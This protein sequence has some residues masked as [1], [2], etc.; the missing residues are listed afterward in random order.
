MSNEEKAIEWLPLSEA[1]KLPEVPVT[2]QSL[3]RMIERGDIPEGHWMEVPFG[4]SRKL[5]L[6]D[7]AILPKL[8]YRESGQRKKSKKL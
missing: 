2:T 4:E 5:Y 8:D 6:I 7:K 3:R 1:V